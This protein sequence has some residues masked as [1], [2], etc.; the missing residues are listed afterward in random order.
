MN[1][2]YPLMANAVYG[3]EK[4]ELIIMIWGIS[5]ER[6]TLN[7]ANRLTIIS[8]LIQNALM[9]ANRYLEALESQRYVEGTRILDAEAFQS[10][11]QAY[12]MARDKGLAECSTLQVKSL[13]GEQEEVAERLRSKL[14]FTD[15]LGRLEDGNLY[16]LLPNTSQVSAETVIQKLQ[17]NGIESYVWHETLE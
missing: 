9:R 3:Q 11:M 17:E 2:S 8:Y 13:P 10:L 12:I 7:Q 5:W 1:S 15:Y 6:M 4:M 14:R 16:V